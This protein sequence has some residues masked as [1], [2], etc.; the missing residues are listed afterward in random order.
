MDPKE[1]MNSALNHWAELLS[2][3]GE[4]EE[5]KAQ[6]EA[7]FAKCCADNGLD[8]VAEKAKRGLRSP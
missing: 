3:E 1:A 8:V 6:A 7:D 5:V 4:L 2:R